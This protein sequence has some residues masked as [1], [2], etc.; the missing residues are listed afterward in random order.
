M[1]FYN[2]SSLK[3]AHLCVNLLKRFGQA[4]LVTALHLCQYKNPFPWLHPKLI[5]NALEIII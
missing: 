2:S 3:F 5:E 4:T 1:A